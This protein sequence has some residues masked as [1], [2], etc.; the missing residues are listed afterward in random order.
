VRESLYWHSIPIFYGFILT[1][2]ITAWLLIRWYKWARYLGLAVVAVSILVSLNSLAAATS[3]GILSEYGID[4]HFLVPCLATAILPVAAA[5]AAFVLP[6]RKQ[7]P[8]TTSA[9][10]AH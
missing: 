4:F 8:P 5:T 7:K 10:C 1:A 3:S 2:P 9:I 6:K